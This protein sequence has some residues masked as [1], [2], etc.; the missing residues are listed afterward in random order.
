MSFGYLAKR[1]ARVLFSRSHVL[2]SRASRTGPG[3]RKPP[4]PAIQARGWAPSVHPIFRREQQ[5][6]NVN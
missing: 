3:I 4:S 6:G 2:T 5:K 1:L